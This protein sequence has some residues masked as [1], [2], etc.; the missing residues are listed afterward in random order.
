[1]QAANSRS[2]TTGSEEE[3]EDDDDDDV[4]DVL[5]DVVSRWL[6]GDELLNLGRLQFVQD[7]QL[8]IVKRQK[9]IGEH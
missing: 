9:R 5:L 3:E 6:S 4:L 1:M 8:F 7:S 2:F